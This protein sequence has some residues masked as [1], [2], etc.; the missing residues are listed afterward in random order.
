MHCS[1]ELGWLSTNSPNS[2]WFRAF[3]AG[4]VLEY[5]SNHQ[6]LGIPLLKFSILSLLYQPSYGCYTVYC[7]IMSAQFT[8]TRNWW[9]V[10][11]KSSA[12][13]NN[14]NIWSVSS[15]TPNGASSAL[16]WYLAYSLASIS[17]QQTAF[18]SHNFNVGVGA[19]SCLWPAASNV[20]TP[21]LTSCS[22]ELA[23]WLSSSGS[24]ESVLLEELSLF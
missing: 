14:E 13:R 18:V 24:C 6:F 21:G 3:A 16:C 19:F 2:S 8:A 17:L 22:V 10:F 7:L 4:A 15:H 1:L 11:L 9:S 12:V 23:T 5:S 20:L